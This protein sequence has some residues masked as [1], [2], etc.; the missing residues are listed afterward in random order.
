MRRCRLLACT[1]LCP[2][3]VTGDPRTEV[4]PRRAP[5]PAVRSQRVSAPAARRVYVVVIGN[6]HQRSS[7]PIEDDQAARRVPL[8]RLAPG[9]DR[10]ENGIKRAAI[11]QLHHGRRS[12]RVVSAETE[13]R[14]MCDRRERDELPK[15]LGA[16][17][18]LTP[19]RVQH[20]HRDR[21]AC[22]ALQRGV[23]Q[24]SFNAL[25]VESRTLRTA[26]AGE[27]KS[28]AMTVLRRRV[29][30]KVAALGRT[31]SRRDDRQSLPP[32]KP[33]RATQPARTWRAPATAATHPPAGRRTAREM[34]GAS[35]AV[36]PSAGT[37]GRHARRSTLMQNDLL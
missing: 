32:A 22:A 21:L 34:R 19:G 11:H 37:R 13:S 30:Q 10:I 33:P 16:R 24:S 35:R 26:D 36:W 14:R 2:S 20:T 28:I 31:D 6:N 29:V 15:E 1:G 17:L 9:V 12:S 3:T 27:T 18:L 25:N 5:A 8:P 4:Q 23:D 7:N